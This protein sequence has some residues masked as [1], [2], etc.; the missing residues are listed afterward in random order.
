MIDDK[1]VVLVGAGGH[2][3]SVVNATGASVLRFV[4]LDEDG[5]FLSGYA[6]ELVV[7]A[8]GYAGEDNPVKSSRR[9]LIDRYEQK[10]VDFGTLVS[11][12]SFVA[13]DAEV[14]PGS[15]VMTRAVVDTG[16]KIG[17]HAVINIGAIIGHDAVLGEN[18]NV[19]LGAVVSGGVHLGDNVFI[20]AGAVLKHGVRVTANA[21]IGMGAV[22][23]ADIA[24]PGTY[25]GCPARR[26]K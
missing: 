7:V 26:I 15:V 19:A 13:Q 1:S 16:V 11:P 8:V 12:D 2:A 25:V 20:G 9:L 3:R 17:R 6:G 23:V 5:S 4:G 21:V 18:V 10:G 24:E 22:V 14:G